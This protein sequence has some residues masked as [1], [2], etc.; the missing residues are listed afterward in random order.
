M[1][2]S[3]AGDGVTSGGS[4]PSIFAE[5]GDSYHFKIDNHDDLRTVLDL[6]EALWV[7]TTAPCTNLKADHVFLEML[8]NDKDGRIRAEEIKDAIKFLFN[9]LTDPGSI[10]EANTSLDLSVINPASDIG[11]RI[12]S[13]AE[14]VLKKLDCDLQSVTLDQVRQ[15]KQQV[16]KGG[17]DQAGIVLPEAAAEQNVE[18]FINDILAT[19]G[20][21]DHPS[22]RCG[23]DSDALDTFTRQCKSY[24]TWRLEAGEIGSSQPTEILVLGP[25]TQRG[26]EVFR[27]LRDKLYQYF[28]LGDIK[29]LN[30][31][32][33]ERALDNPEVNA[34]YNL[35]NIED[36]E[37]YLAT[38]PLSLLSDDGSLD[39]DGEINP[40]FITVLGKF[41]ETVVKPLLGEQISKLDKDGFATLRQLFKP[42][43]EWIERKPETAVEALGDER[44]QHYTSTPEYADSLKSLIDQSHQTAIVLENLAELERLI[45]YQ[46]WMLPLVNSFV[47]F[48]HL[49]DPD[50]RALFEEGTLI[51]DGR[52]FNMALKVNDRQQHIDTCKGSSIFVLYCELFGSNGEKLHEIAVPVT[53]GCRGTLRLNKWGIFN[54]LDGNELHAKVV[55]IVANPIS[56]R[57]AVSDPFIRIRDSFFSRLEEFSS[58]AEEKV[59]KK[60]DKEKKKEASATPLLGMGG[61]AVAALGSALAFITQTL[62]SMSLNTV[63]IALL[64]IFLLIIVPT[65]ISAYARLSRRDLSTILE[66]SGWGL[67]SRMK[68]TR[69][70][71]NH[72]THRPGRS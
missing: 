62:A 69:E 49:Y 33:L 52:H 59:F 2:E 6:D 40:Y 21:P 11:R 32:L 44:I 27:Q 16:L 55:D 34:A 31:D 10:R 28:L 61:V 65:A 38:A 71:A 7:A 29:R 66:G 53:S 23:V 43:K 72:F 46:A 36:A 17:L 42:Y 50:K 60:Q 56:V 64:V 48:P 19:V 4:G 35:I 39:L 51:M 30:P 5:L 58:K 18:Q 13:S 67:N 8:D 57:E 47:S 14:K 22:G 1:S 12:K 45:L 70:Q 63:L 9:T 26:Y 25:D 37:S 3:T 20:G 54:D 15:I 68:L 41:R 24:L